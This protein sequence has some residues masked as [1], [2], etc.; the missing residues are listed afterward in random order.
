[1][2]SPA[3]AGA[4]VRRLLTALTL[5]GLLLAAALGG[6]QLHAD[7]RAS[8]TMIATVSAAGL[9][10]PLLAELA[11]ARLAALPLAALL[12]AAAGLAG[13]L[14]LAWARIRATSGAPARTWRRAVLLPAGTQTLVR[15]AARWPQILLVVP[16]AC[17]GVGAACLLPAGDPAATALTPAAWLLGGGLIALGFPLLLAERLLAAVPADALPEA[18]E[19]RALAF[20]A[21]LAVVTAGVLE[22]A[23][24]L[25]APGLALRL[26]G[27]LALLPAA[28][29][30]ELGLRAAVRGFLPP[31]PAA[32]AWAAS[33]SM[34]ARVFAEGAAARS[35]AVPVRRHL[36]IDFAGS[37]ALAYVRAA[38]APLALLLVLIGWGLSGVALVPLDQRAVYERF[39]A[40]VRVLPP[41]L[42]LLLPWPF[43]RL[44]PVEFGSM[45]ELAL[46]GDSARERFA[47]EDVPPPGA[48]RLWDMENPAET[49]FL[50]ASA[51]GGKQGFQMVSADIR[52]FWRVGLSDADALR[53]TYGAV[54]PV[55]LLRQSAGRVAA[56]FFAG[57][58]LDAVLGENRETMAGRLRAAVQR[59]L[60]EA[61]VGLELEAVVIEAL[62][63]PG[64]A[65]D[66]Y[67][68][69]QAAQIDAEASISAERGRA[70]T[71]LS[72]QHQL[73]TGALRG[74]EA[75]AAET[76]GAARADAIRFAAEH[77]A[78][79]GGAP[80][81]RMERRLAAL[82]A[83]LSAAGGLTL[84]D[85]RLPPG[86]APLLDFR[87]MPGSGATMPPP[88]LS[89]PAQDVPAEEPAN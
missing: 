60:D 20:L 18:P 83:V 33:N 86:A 46:K 49:W 88:D 51:R 1:M 10:S 17:L 81:Y 76:L 32:T 56:A 64:G 69:V 66:A 79:R 70:F 19:L 53:A 9:P 82:K 87:P 28:V 37:W 65:A 68:A 63:P 74:A 47:A 29:A 84:F 58:T 6:L 41:G 75:D 27:L 80:P 72:E 31:P 12:A 16:L 15:R 24:G 34:L 25:G 35:L 43:G 26:A 61:G 77:D 59:A 45:H 50:V 8:R 52:L 7:A 5:G 71:S 67:H 21:T 44:R 14:I 55:G 30:T 57:R 54:D 89:P 40:P 22:L 73:A 2:T 62:H 13:A 23:A 3:P 48:D 85:H 78:D 42:H 36:G 11:R 39:G 4:E 38:F